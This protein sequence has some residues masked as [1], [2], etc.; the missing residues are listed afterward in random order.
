MLKTSIVALFCL[1]SLS[2][3]A[4]NGFLLKGRIK[5][6]QE[7]QKVMLDYRDN[8]KVV[9]DSVMVKNGIFLLKGKVTD[10]VQAKIILKDMVEDK[11]PM[12]REKM[13]ALDMQKFYLENKVFSIEG[14]HMKTAVIKGGHAQEDYTVLK[15]E[16]KPLEDRMKT[17]SEKMEQYVKEKNTQ[18]REE[19]F[20]Q[21]RN[22]RLEISNTEEEFMRQH[23]DSYVTLDLLNERSVLIDVKKAGPAFD[24]LSPRLKSSA[25]GKVLGERIHIAMKTAVGKPA[26]NFVQNDTEGRPVSLTSLK[27]KYVLVDFWA[28]WC[29]PCRA[30][31]PNVL[32]AYNKYK[33]K[34]FEIIAISL[35]DEKEP[36]L[37]AIKADGLPWI[38]VSDL[39]GW[40]NEVAILYD[41]RAVPQNFL[42]GPDGIIVGKNLRG[43]KLEKKLA[44]LIEK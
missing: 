30:E 31:N 36:W 27:G 19:L 32:K 17:L 13:A 6:M 20:P 10:A 4:Q 11:G 24:A 39:K 16:L 44:E 2:A 14:D 33:D 26:L 34:N 8:G 25:Q 28:S 22:L 41:V 40:K 7:G 5:G 12:T 38:Q 42:V 23:N 37:K 35:D 29:G 43:D 21:V 1:L 9:K 15:S 18:K 3:N